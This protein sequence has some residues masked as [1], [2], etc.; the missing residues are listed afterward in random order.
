MLT[1]GGFW[2]CSEIQAERM[3]E[4]R[5]QDILTAFNYLA[6]E[7]ATRGENDWLSRNEAERT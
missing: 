3:N 6:A 2:R 5:G 7:F 4:K 1:E